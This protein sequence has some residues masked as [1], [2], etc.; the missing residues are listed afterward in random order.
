MTAQQ[1]LGPIGV[2]AMEKRGLNPETAARLGVF[3]GKAVYREEDGRR[4]IDRVD[5]DDGGNILVFP[6][7]EGGEIVGEK[8]RGPNK[9]FFQKP[10]SRQT[11]INGDVLDD[12]SLHDGS[13]PLVIVEGEPDL[14][15]AIDSGFPLSVS[16][17]AGAPNPPKERPPADEETDD[18]SGKFEF[19]WHNRERLKKVKRFIIAVDNDTNGKYLADELVRRLGASRCSFVTY[20]DGCKDLNDVLMKHGVEAACAVL[21]QARPYPLRG[22]Y[23]LADYPDRPQVQTFTTGW[24]TVDDLFRPFAPSF[25]IVTGLPGSGKSTWLTNLAVNMADAHGWKWG[26]FSPELPVV[27]FYRDKIRRIVAGDTVERL[28]M[29]QI[30]AADRW[31]NENFVFIDYDV[32]IDDESD[33]TVEWLLKRAYD[34]LMR[35]GIRGFIIDPWNEIEH[36]RSKF[37]NETCYINRALRQVIKFGRRHGLATFVLAHPTK[38]V[39]K[40]GKSRVPTLYDI[41]G[42]AAWFNKPDFGI[43]VDRPDPNVDRTN[44]WIKKVRFEGTGARGHCVLQFN[45]DNSRF[46]LLNQ[47]PLQS[48]QYE[49]EFT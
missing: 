14:I 34:A 22:I 20:P 10:E 37:E 13:N 11:F 18:S 39:G 40:D 47:Q 24:S 2:A 26:I 44:I 16:V 35:Y 15:S 4:V 7:I 17:P 46:E 23:A 1:T 9:F 32:A 49:A 25:T 19:M 33:L 45:R 48:G 12:P 43:V 38:D 8:Y 28:T 27:P 31:I 5:P 3:T 36:A 41:E 42:S 21:S 6:I 29:E 30:A